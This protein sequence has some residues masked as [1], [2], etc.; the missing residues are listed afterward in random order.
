MIGSVAVAALNAVA[1]TPTLLQRSRSK[2]A[3]EDRPTFCQLGL[4]PPSV[5]TIPASPGFSCS[6]TRRY[7]TRPVAVAI[8]VNPVSDYSGVRQCSAGSRP[9]GRMVCVRGCEAGGQPPSAPG[10]SVS[11]RIARSAPRTRSAK[12]GTPGERPRLTG[13]ASRPPSPGLLFERCRIARRRADQLGSLLM[14][15]RRRS[16]IYPTTF[17]RFV[18]TWTSQAPVPSASTL[19]TLRMTET[20]RREADRF[21]PIQPPKPRRPIC[22]HLSFTEQIVHFAA[23]R[24]S[25]ADDLTRRRRMTKLKRKKVIHWSSSAAPS[26]DVPDRHKI[27]RHRLLNRKYAAGSSC[28]R[29]ISELARR[30]PTCASSPPRCWRRPGQG[31]SFSK[32]YSR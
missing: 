12:W 20:T 16:F 10:R 22:Q 6:R 31:G 32:F 8:L 2:F 9:A 14:V 19:S 27:E 26:F 11:R 24:V 23:A 15:E 4:V 30:R 5:P 21:V 3:N 7:T 18:D 29:D 25:G 28:R 1:R 17:S 13:T